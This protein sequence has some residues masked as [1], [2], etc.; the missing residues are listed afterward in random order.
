LII[1]IWVLVAI[2]FSW[3][4]SSKFMGTPGKIIMK[5]KITDANGNRIS[6]MA[7]L[8]RFI[9]K[10]ALNQ[11]FYAGS[12]FILFNDNKQGLYDLLLNT[13]VIKVE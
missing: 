9:A 5:L 11:I 12:L 8:L 2:Y 7:A 10:M 4:E 3:F 1:V 6:F 13:Y